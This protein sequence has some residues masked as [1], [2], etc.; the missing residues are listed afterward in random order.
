MTGIV[1][2][3]IQESHFDLDALLLIERTEEITK[4][5]PG[6]LPLS[7]IH[8][9]P[10][11]FQWRIENDSLLTSAYHVKELA[12][13][14]S[15]QDKPFEPLLVTPIGNRF[16][17]ID[18]HHRLEAYRSASW[19]R[20]I[21]VEISEKCVKEA[22][23]EALT[24]NNQ[25]K[26]PMSLES[27]QEAAWKLHTSRGSTGSFLHS[28]S[29]IRKLTTVSDGTIS[30]MR[31]A[32]KDG[33]KPA[34]V[35]WRKLRAAKWHDDNE[36]FD[37]DKH[38]EEKSRQIAEKLMSTIKTNLMS[39]P[40]IF[41]RAIEMVSPQLPKALIKEWLRDASEVVQEYQAELEEYE[42]LDI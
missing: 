38:K 37:Y 12:R 19:T 31:R 24:R 30:S 25:D 2:S 10:E 26:L 6:S 39:Q 35:S 4:D 28:K 29:T 27:K 34:L 9:A 11:V 36:D 40:D 16:F 3:A 7:K 23:L 1:P 32:I 22:Q 14:L 8:T 42:E 41:A 33:A 20:L 21:P 5:R 13:A 17:V 15:A 18:G